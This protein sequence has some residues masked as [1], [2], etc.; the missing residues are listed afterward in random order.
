MW[1]LPPIAGATFVVHGAALPRRRALWLCAP[2]IGGGIVPSLLGGWPGTP[3]WQDRHPREGTHP[4]QVW[5]MTAVAVGLAG[6]P[7]APAGQTLLPGPRAGPL[8][9]VAV[10]LG[11]L[12]A[13]LPARQGSG[14]G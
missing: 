10:V 14:S 1:A 6:A 5:G 9:V 7:L 2:L 13:L 12:L 8:A 4:L 11:A 3:E